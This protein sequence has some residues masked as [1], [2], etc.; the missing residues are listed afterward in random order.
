MIRR[1]SNNLGNL[2][3]S[4]VLAV[5]VWIVA[6]QETYPNIDKILD[7]PI[8]IV[9]QNQPGNMVVYD[10]SAHTMRITVSAPQSSLDV[11]TPDRIA[12]TI[13]LSRQPSGTLELPVQVAINDRFVRITK[14]EPSIVRLKMEPLDTLRLPATIDVVGTSALGYAARPVTTTPMTIVVRG[15]ASLVQRVVTVDGQLS[16]QDARATVSQTVGLTPR[17]SDGQPVPNITLTPSTTL[18]IV[19]VQQLGGFR[20]LAV[21]IDLRGNVASGYLIANVS[22]NPQIA[23]VFGSPTTLD[24]LPGFISTEPVSVTNATG[25]LDKRVRLD[26]PSGVSMLGDPFV[27]VSVQ[28]EPIESSLT[29]QR[30][31]TTQG[32]QPSFTA[33]L[34]PELVDVIVSGPVPILDT[35]RADDVQVILNLLNLDIGTHQLTPEVS[36]PNGLTVVSVLPATIQVVISE[37]IT[38]TT[39]ITAT[40]PIPSPLPTP[41]K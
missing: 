39:T 38:P 40:T 19:P 30:A 35:L 8:P 4:I 18:A 6:V 7:T 32:L 25:N 17:A 11:L 16:I 34:S 10:E 28:V 1:I 22:V 9:A 14:V 21:K 27:Q 33:R 2:I 23:T 24:A 12:A 29:L 13:D 41:K 3:L 37:A 31:P 15:P 5:L 26:L 20:D 36:V